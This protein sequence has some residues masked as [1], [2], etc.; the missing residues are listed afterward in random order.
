M[1]LKK[2]FYRVR[3]SLLMYGFAWGIW[4]A[5]FINKDFRSRL[6]ETPFNF[7]MGVKDEGPVRYFRCVNG[8]LRS[9]RKPMEPMAGEFGLMW[10]DSQ[11]GG[12]AMLDMLTGKPKALYDAVVA[13]VLLLEGDGKMVA[14]FL[15]TVT[16]LNR[17]FRSKKKPS[18]SKAG[19]DGDNKADTS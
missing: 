18:A 16:Q 2:I 19:S 10:R 6:A 11:A 12:Q 17:V 5:G 15:Q 8:R 7:R 1:L 14:W 9:S 3:L 4:F 13:G